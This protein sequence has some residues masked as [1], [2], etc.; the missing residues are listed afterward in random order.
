MWKGATSGSWSDGTSHFTFLKKN[1]QLRRLSNFTRHCQCVSPMIN[2]SHIKVHSHT[3]GARGGNQDM[4]CTKQGGGNS[5]I[6]L[7]VDAHGMPVRIR[8]TAG[9]TANCSQGSTLI[10]GIDARTCWRTRATTLVPSELR[11]R[12]KA[13][14][15]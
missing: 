10:D 4:G 12:D 1:S 13:W 3:A 15:L 8:V 14:N 2:A 11:Q 5:K 6:H 7:A 9:S